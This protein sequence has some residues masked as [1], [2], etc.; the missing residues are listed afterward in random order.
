MEL[1]LAPNKAEQVATPN[2]KPLWWITLTHYEYWPW[3]VLYAPMLLVW[4]YH[5]LRTRKWGYFTAINPSFPEGGFYNYSKKAVLDLVPQQYKPITLLVDPAQPLLPQLGTLPFPM[6]AKPDVGERGNGVAKVDNLNEIQQYHHTATG[7]YIVQE[8][9]DYDLELAVLYSKQPNEAQGR[10]SSVTVKGFLSVTGDGTSTLAELV[11]ANERARFQTDRLQREFEK[12]W[13]NVIGNGH[14]MLLEPIGNHCRG[15]RFIKANHMID[16]TL[17]AVFE[18][19]AQQI[20][21]LQYGRFDLRARSWQDLL[22]GEHIRIVELNGVSADPAH[23]YDNSHGLWSTYRDLLWHWNRIARICRANMASGTV[24]PLS[25]KETWA[26][27]RAR[28]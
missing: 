9:A 4:L 11:A 12:H 6:V 3:L 16:P 13:S 20:P 23:I 1:T 27:F 18:N 10:V 15:T 14:T 28:N 17:N 7:P 5:V 24:Q 8:Y 26:L 19:I 21:G 25:G 2:T 22:K